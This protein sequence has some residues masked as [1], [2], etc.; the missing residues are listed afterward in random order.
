M[1]DMIDNMEKLTFLCDIEAPNLLRS[2]EILEAMSFLFTDSNGKSAIVTSTDYIPDPLKE[3]VVIAAVTPGT[4]IIN[5]ESFK[6]CPNLK[7]VILPDSVKTI[8]SNAFR[9]CPNLQNITIPNNIETIESN[10]FGTCPLTTRIYNDIQYLGNAGNP[11]V[12]AYKA[13]DNKESYTLHQNT[14]VIYDRTFID[15]KAMTSI[16]IP[17]S[18][19]SLG[20]SAFKNSGLTSVKLPDS[21]TKIND[22]TFNGCSALSNVT[23]GAR[24]TEVGN[25]AFYSCTSLKNV[26]IPD[27]VTSIGDE[28]FYDCSM[29]NSV[30]FEEDS[31][32]ESIGYAAFGWCEILESITIPDSVTSIG[33]SAFEYCESLTSVTIGNGVTSIGEYAFQGCD[34][35]TSVTIGNNVTSI[36]VYA[37]LSC[38]SLTSINIPN[39]V[40]YIGNNAFEDC[41]ALSQVR[42][43]SVKQLGTEAFKGC[44]SLKS[45]TI[46]SYNTLIGKKAFA[47]CTELQTANIKSTTQPFGNAIFENC[48]S[49][50][51]LII[52][53]NR[54][55]GQ[56]DPLYTNLGYLFGSDSNKDVPSTLTSLTVIGGNI[57][58][59]TFI[60]CESIETLTIDAVVVRP[61]AFKN[62]TNLKQINCGN[63]KQLSFGENAF[64][65]CTSL[66]AVYILEGDLNNWAG[67]YFYNYAANPLYYAK[68]LLNYA[69]HRPFSEIELSC[70]RITPL[71][72]YNCKTL[73]QIIMTNNVQFISESAFDSCSNLVSVK[74][75]SNVKRADNSQLAINDISALKYYAFN[76]CYKLVEVIASNDQSAINKTNDGFLFYKDDNNTDYLLGHT[77]TIMLEASN[78]ALPESSAYGT[79]YVIYQHAFADSI[80]MI[81]D[82]DIPATVLEIRSNAFSGCGIQTLDCTKNKQITI[83][84]SYAF[85]KCKNLTAI[86]LP[87][88]I[89]E[90]GFHAFDSCENLTYTGISIDQKT[91]P[92]LTTISSGAFIDCTSLIYVEI[93]ASI[94]KIGSGAF[95]RCTSLSS[96]SF[97]HNSWFGSYESAPGESVTAF[98]TTNTT[99][100]TNAL[101]ANALLLKDT[102]GRYDWQKTNSKT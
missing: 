73:T 16:D 56:Q 59:E 31:V 87:P 42:L 23:L 9:N 65:N 54:Q 101:Y 38:A 50:Q 85:S 29:L 64:Y 55:V 17:N 96:A 46:E 20:D 52:P 5:T 61:R 13:V 44:T 76:D 91:C 32:C 75:G 69:D 74:L 88:N 8:K 97:D 100:D 34:S 53:G 84:G 49:L 51:A 22:G 41:T 83:F 60:D 11:Y 67:V 39:S 63:V 68:R 62:C 81:G 2:Y 94:E 72:F 71:A 47:N 4:E 70:Q 24:T 1:S 26:T 15:C 93:P 99:N 3:S 36:G 58:E 77:E 37:F 82:L 7:M 90:I 28:A 27:S 102:F 98:I 21:I 80:G 43:L 35:L 6:D 78:L 95:L 66:N 48:T 89:T 57:K 79:S 92:S 40:E 25:Q 12:V 10:A 30:E 19:S 86:S 45:V 33:D 18:V 14:K